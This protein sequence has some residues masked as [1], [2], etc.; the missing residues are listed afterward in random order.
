MGLGK[1]ALERHCPALSEESVE[2]HRGKVTTV[3]G[4]VSVLREEKIQKHMTT[5]EAILKA[6]H[7]IPQERKQFIESLLRQPNFDPL[8]AEAIRRVYSKLYGEPP[9]G[10]NK[11]K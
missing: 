2:K 4:L 7:K 10:G 5:L 1:V 11:T 6:K 8:E 3:E 9:K